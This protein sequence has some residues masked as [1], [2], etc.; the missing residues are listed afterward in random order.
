M[1][2]FFFQGIST[3]F[4]FFG[5]MVAYDQICEPVSG[6]TVKCAV[7]SL[8]RSHTSFS[9]VENAAVSSGK[10]VSQGHFYDE[11][12]VEFTAKGAN[13]F[14]IAVEPHAGR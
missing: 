7:S 6:T 10:L 3:L 5:E 13:V 14:Q 9:R 12:V 2:A 8:R 1:A 11:D 4:G